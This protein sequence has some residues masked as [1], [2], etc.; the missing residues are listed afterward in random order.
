MFD[1]LKK[2]F[3]IVSDFKKKIFFL[4]LFFFITAVLDI[5]G[6]SLIGPF[7]S[8]SLNNNYDFFYILNIKNLSNEEIFFIVCLFIF[9]LFV[10]KIFISLFLSKL[11]INFA[12]F[13]QV[14]LRLKFLDKIQKSSF[15]ELNKK[16]MSEYLNIQQS[17]IPIFS[18]LLMGL[19]QMLGELIIG[20]IIIIYLFIKNPIIFSFLVTL[21]ILTILL[22]DLYARKSLII[23]GKEG[24]LY[25]AKMI[26]FIK[27]GL[28]GFKEIKI[29]NKENF[30]KNKLDIAATKYA[31]SQININFMNIIPRYLIEIIMVL[32][33]IIIA[34]LIKYINLNENGELIPLLGVYAFGAVR[35]LPIAR[36]IS[37]TLNRLNASSDSINIL[38]D[39]FKTFEKRKDILK[40]TKFTKNFNKLKLKDIYFS[41]SNSKNKILQKFNLEIKKSQ[42]ILIKGKSG[43]GKTTLLNIIMGLLNTEKGKIYL[44]EN[45][46]SDIRTINYLFA[47]I[48]QESFII[49]DTLENNISLGERITKKNQ[50]KLNKAINEAGLMDLVNSL[51]DNEKTILGEG[52]YSLSGGQKQKVAI[53][54]AIYHERSI[55][56]LDEATNALDNKSEGEIFSKIS[57]NKNL[58]V[59]AVSHKELSNYKYNIL[60][61]L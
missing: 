39:Q 25:S 23:S 41:Y 38:N 49:N 5:L 11:V 31:L 43:R 45:L 27:D 17:V 4:V 61:N 48:P 55:L 52:G 13:Q 3:F 26:S 54:R 60:I 46:I 35:I 32:T 44:N 15:S 34:F 51:S 58:T 40:Q 7:L 20:L 36:N 12:Q 28:V 14:H 24:N 53:A 56:V 42:K 18:N 47:Y 50:F 9:I 33:L 21:I 57:K 30:I 59:I 1:R 19:V 10:L 6:L 8:M 16:S 2:L 22:Y 29:F 37:Y